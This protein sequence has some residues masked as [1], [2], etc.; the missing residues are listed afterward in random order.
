MVK[1]G[2]DEGRGRRGTRKSEKILR[3]EVNPR[4]GENERV[5]KMEEIEREKRGVRT[6][7]R[8]HEILDSPVSDTLFD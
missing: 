2:R 8:L 7:Q 1:T 5:R 6:P 3:E 4:E